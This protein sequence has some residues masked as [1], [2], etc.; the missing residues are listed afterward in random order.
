MDRRNSTFQHRQ[1]PFNNT[2]NTEMKN[3][4]TDRTLRHI[5]NNVDGPDAI[6]KDNINNNIYIFYQYFIFFFL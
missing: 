5:I 2:D 3:Y 1:N 6:K 4:C